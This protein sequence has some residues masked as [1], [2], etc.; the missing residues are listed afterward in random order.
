VDL[1]LFAGLSGP[2]WLLLIASVGLGLGLEL[3]FY[4]RQRARRDDRDE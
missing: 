4:W 1:P 3:L 2:A